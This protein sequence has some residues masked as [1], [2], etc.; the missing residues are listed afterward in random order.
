MQHRLQEWPGRNDYCAPV[1]HGDGGAVFHDGADVDHIFAFGFDGAA[2]EADEGA[3]GE[4]TL[5]DGVDE[6]AGVDKGLEK[7]GTVTSFGNL[8]TRYPYS[9]VDTSSAL[10]APDIHA[11]CLMTN[12][13]H[14]VVVPR[15]ACPG[16]N[17]QSPFAYLLCQPPEIGGVQITISTGK[18]S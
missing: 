4:D 15:A 10:G 7:V 14:L 8:R 6:E 2:E 12:H 11:Y 9:S 16:I 17:G 3:V 18:P 13:V 5:G 1:G